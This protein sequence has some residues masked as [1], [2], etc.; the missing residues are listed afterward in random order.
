MRHLLFLFSGVDISIQSLR[1]KDR[2]H[3]YSNTVVRGRVFDSN[4]ETLCA[5]D[6]FFRYIGEGPDRRITCGGGIGLL[7]TKCAEVRGA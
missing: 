4:K 6:E 5:S 2:K 1:Y 3:P 7:H